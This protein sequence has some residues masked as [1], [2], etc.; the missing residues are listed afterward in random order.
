MTLVREIKPGVFSIGAIDWDRRLFDALIALPDGTSYNSYL[1]RG[2]NKIAL[3]DAVDSTM[4]DVLIE[5]LNALG[6]KK[7]DYII[8]QHAEQDHTGSLGRLVE[9]YPD[10]TVAG[11]ARCLELLV[12]FGLVDKKRTQELKDGDVIDLGG[13]SLQII[14]APWVHWPDT[15]L[16]YLASDRI[17]FSCDFL[18]SHLA[19]STLYADEAVVYRA[20]K[21]YYAEI[22]MPFRQHIR[23]HLE[24]ISN[25]DIDIIAPSHGPIHARP[26]FILNAYGEWASDEVKNQVVLP[27]VSMHGS[28]KA[29]TDYIADALIA[30]G[31]EVKRFD[32]TN[33]DIGLLAEA[34]VD[35][36]TI[37]IGTPTMLSGA[38]PLALYAAILANA[39]RPK[40]RYAS[41]IGSYGWG[42]KMLEQI[43]QAMPNLKLQLF[44][45]VVAKGYPKEADF[46]R[47]DRLADEILAK[48]RELM[49]AQSATK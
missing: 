29:M 14:S 37:V 27:F 39:L 11:S 15:I 28:T 30:R 48:H 12:E 41:I 8:V 3:I 17:L 13:K 38:H 45:P 21:R 10:S 35:A 9:L 42:G 47:L 46:R 33:S 4:A 34:L 6:I 1:V 36:S 49:H 40:T 2:K 20:A 16:S 32:L 18:G 19:T 24:R 23:K 26:E 7:I 25:Y 44:D 31:I 22:M 5:N 43:T